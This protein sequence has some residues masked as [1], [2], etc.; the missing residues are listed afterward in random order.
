MSFD[1]RKVTSDCRGDC[2]AAEF[3]QVEL[4]TKLHRYTCVSRIVQDKK[5]PDECLF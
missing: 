1:S 3:K 2:M 5:V 4:L